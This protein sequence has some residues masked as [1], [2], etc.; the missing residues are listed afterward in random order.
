MLDRSRLREQPLPTSPT[1]SARAAGSIWRGPRGVEVARPEGQQV[2]VAQRAPAAPAQS[3]GSAACAGEGGHR[4]HPQG[5]RGRLAGSAWS[6]TRSTSIGARRGSSVRAGPGRGR[7]RGARVDTRE[8]GHKRP[9][10]AARWR[11]RTPPAGAALVRLVVAD[12]RGQVATGWLHAVTRRPT[13]RASSTIPEH[14]E[15]RSGPA[16]PRGWHRPSRMPGQDAAHCMNTTSTHPRHAGAVARSSGDSGAA[17]S[18]ST[19]RRA[20]AKCR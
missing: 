5:G 15:D 18:E 9:V 2:V 4:L 10:G 8:P 12:D 13:L 17:I 6:P 7:Q 14:P 1:G 3:V 16:R 11:R 19:R 20:N